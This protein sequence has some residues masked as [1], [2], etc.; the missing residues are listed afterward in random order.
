MMHSIRRLTWMVLMVA[1]AAMLGWAA[2]Q[3]NRNGNEKAGT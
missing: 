3:K 1:I 2:Q